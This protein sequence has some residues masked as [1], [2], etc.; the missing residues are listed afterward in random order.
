[1]LGQPVSVKGI[2]S[3][4]ADDWTITEKPA[5]VHVGSP[6]GVNRWLLELPLSLSPHEINEI[7]AAVADPRTWTGIT[8][9][10]QWA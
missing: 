5:D 3:I 1:V 2:L 7:A 10:G 8:H 4:I 6:R 9:Q